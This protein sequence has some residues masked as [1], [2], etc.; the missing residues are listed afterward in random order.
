[1]RIGII[2]RENEEEAWGVAH[3]RFPDDRQ[4]QIAHSLALKVSDS[5][6]HHQLSVRDG[7][8]GRDPYWILPFQN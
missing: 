6:W 7:G 8:G 4:R 3:E 2:A 5:R 1:V